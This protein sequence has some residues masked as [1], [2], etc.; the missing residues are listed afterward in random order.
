MDVPIEE[1][2]FE[3]PT[4]ERRDAEKKMQVEEERYNAMA[5]AFWLA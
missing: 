2:D 3:R 1:T 5:G 4:G